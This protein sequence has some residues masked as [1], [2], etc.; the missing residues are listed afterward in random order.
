M[1]QIGHYS[2]ACLHIPNTGLVIR[3]GRYHSFVIGAEADVGFLAVVV[4][5]HVHQVLGIEDAGLDQALV[6]DVTVV[7][8]QGMKQLDP[9]AV[10]SPGDLAR[11]TAVAA[12]KTFVGGDIEVDRPGVAI[13]V[14]PAAFAGVDVVA[15]QKKVFALGGLQ[16]VPEGFAINAPE[17]MAGNFHGHGALVN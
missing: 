4:L 1:V 8:R 2:P 9:F 3:T 10:G 6:D 5:G 13:H 15:G 12:E 17:F 11:V 14:V 7:Q 16:V